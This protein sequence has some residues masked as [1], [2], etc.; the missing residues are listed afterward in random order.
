[1]EIRVGP[2]SVPARALV[3]EAP[4]GELLIGTPKPQDGGRGRRAPASGPALP[5]FAALARSTDPGEAV[6]EFVQRYGRLH[7]C[8]EHERP[9]FPHHRDCSQL[10]PEPLALWIARSEEVWRLLHTAESLKAGEQ[11]DPFEVRHSV[12][13]ESPFPA[14]RLEVEKTLR[15][16]RELDAHAKV[17]QLHLEM[18]GWEEEW[19]AI[20]RRRDRQRHQFLEILPSTPQG[21][22]EWLAREISGHLYEY[23]VSVGF[24]IDADDAFQLTLRDSMSV[25]ARVYFELAM[26]V[27][28]VGRLASCSHCG[29]PYVPNRAPKRGQRNYCPECREAHVPQRLHMRERRAR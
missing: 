24:E 26:E 14:R 29:R 3:V 10:D 6:V 4:D 12:H 18:E 16:F 21:W 5:E 23:P 22:R 9:I 25:L 19:E 13:K 15:E 7:L 8:R 20:H 28:G 11:P 1:M 27:A 17:E 2:A